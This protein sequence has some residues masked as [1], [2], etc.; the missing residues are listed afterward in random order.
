MKDITFLN[1]AKEV[2]TSSK[3]ISLQVGCVL[4]FEGEVISTGYN[5]TNSG[6]INCCDGFKKGLFSRKEHS[7]WSKK[8]ET[9][10]ELNALLRCKTST[11]GATAYITQSPCFNCVKHLVTAGIKSIYFLEKY[12]RLS[13]EDFKEIVDYCQEMA[14]GLIQVTPSGTHIYFS[15]GQTEV[16]KLFSYNFTTGELFWRERCA[17]TISSR[18]WASWNSKH[19]GQPFGANH[20]SHQTTYLRGTINGKAFLAHRL[21]WLYLK[22]CWPRKQ[23]DHIDGNGLNNKEVNLREVDLGDNLRNMPKRVDNTSGYVGVRQ[24]PS[25]SWAVY[26]K[27][28]YRGC[29]N[30]L[31]EAIM[32]RQ[33][34]E[35]EEGFHENHGR[36]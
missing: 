3:C 15:L 26:I 35:I 13:S 30:T 27:S 16:K 32:F 25:G 19:A 24:L 2:A 34:L 36:E 12:R 23:I 8:W 14:I 7:E 5:G 22:G 33:T 1:L 28:K 31:E 6:H 18:V 4:A 9:H 20:K 10:S 11:K 17:N 29:K 21:I